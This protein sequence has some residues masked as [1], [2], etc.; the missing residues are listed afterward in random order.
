V[1]GLEAFVEN[2]EPVR[3]FFAAWPSF[4]DAEVV[5]MYLSRGHIYPG[6]SDERNVLPAL[7]IK[8]RVLEAT[9]AGA[10]GAGNDVLVTLRFRD[11]SAIKVLS[12]DDMVSITGIAVTPVARGT[13]SLGE[14]LA[15]RL[16]VSINTGQRLAASFS[17]LGI[18]VVEAI[19]CG[20]K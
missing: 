13:Y 19:R 2:G 8:L 14:P 12:F 16:D 4:H 5:E 10:A 11:A 6:G 3:S 9:Q 1:D 18:Q 15:P 20:D 17:C 7:T